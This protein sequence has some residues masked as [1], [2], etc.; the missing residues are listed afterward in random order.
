MKRSIQWVFKGGGGVCN[1]GYLGGFYMGSGEIT[2]GLIGFHKTYRER[3]TKFQSVPGFQEDSKI[4]QWFQIVSYI[5]KL[6]LGE[7]EHQNCQSICYGWGENRCQLLDK[8]FCREWRV[9]FTFVGAFSNAKAIVQGISHYC[10][11]C[12]SRV[13]VQGGL[14]SVSKGSTMFQGRF[15][16]SQK[17]SG[18]AV[19]RSV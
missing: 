13:S 17:D 7:V 15:K 11:C 1:S 5:S 3:F 10:L 2:G 6:I 9:F 18:W 4:I 16:R 12:G 19:F 14:Q 8:I